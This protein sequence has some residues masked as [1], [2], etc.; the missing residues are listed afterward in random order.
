MSPEENNSN[1]D[2]SQ[3]TGLSKIKDEQAARERAAN[4]TV[5]DYDR[6]DMGSPEG[7]NINVNIDNIVG[8]PQVKDKLDAERAEAE[9]AA[10]LERSRQQ[11]GLMSLGEGSFD[12][13]REDKKPEVVRPVTPVK[14]EKT[15]LSGPPLPNP[16]REYVNYTYNLSFH[17]I[18]PEIYNRMAVDKNYVY[19][20]KDQ[21]GRGTVLIAS[22]GRRDQK[23]FDRHPEFK[24]DFYFENLK[25]TTVV[26]MNSRSRHSNAIEINFTL[27]EPYGFTLI[28]RLLKI[29]DQLNTKSWMQIPFML[30]ID[31]M[32][33]T[34]EGSVLHP[35]PNQTKYL[36]VKLIGCKSKVTPRGAEYQLQCVPFNHQAFTETIASTPAHFEVQATTIKDFFSVTGSAGEAENIIRVRKAGK[37]R[38]DQLAKQIEDEKKKDP[39]SPRIAELGREINSLNRDI[40]T[41]GYQVGSYAAALNSYQLQLQKNNHIRITEEFNFVFDPE[42]AD[43]KIVVPKKTTAN[44]TQMLTLGTPGG[45]AAIRAQAGLPTVGANTNIETFAINAGTNI[46]EVISMAMRNSEFIRNQIIDPATEPPENFSVPQDGQKAADDAGK[47]IVWFKIIPVLELREFDT[48]RDIYAKKITYHVKKFTY[49]NTKFRD[50]PKSRPTYN[51]KEYHYMYSGK[52]ESILSFDI[53]FDVMFYTAITADRGKIQTTTVQSKQPDDNKDDSQSAERPVGVTNNVTQMVS[54][55]ADQVNPGSPDSKASLV[56]DFSKSMMSSSRGDMINVNLKI[57]G[58]P[59]LIKQDDLFFN[60]ANN[61]DQRVDQIVDP[62]SN[63]IIFDATEVFALLTFRT[64]TDINLNTGFMNFDQAEYSVFSGV[65]KIITVENEF[66]R[67]QFTQ[68]LQLVRLFDQPAWDSPESMKL[69]SRHK[70]DNRPLT[71]AEATNPTPNPSTAPTPTTPVTLTVGDPIDVDLFTGVDEAVA[72]QK[73]ENTAAEAAALERSRQ[74]MGLMSLGEGSFNGGDD[75]GSNLATGGFFGGAARRKYEQAKAAGQ[76]TTT[77]TINPGVA[78]DQK[79]L[80]NQ[81]EDIPQIDYS[82]IFPN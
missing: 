55:Q 74:Q 75:N 1:I 2:F 80:R 24:E 4:Q 48:K 43:S 56:N 25:F 26:G 16:L 45:I 9:R 54:G 72:R 12:G 58:D 3:I 7:N 41:M 76:L 35:I 21:N 14:V 32:G 82:A 81:L 57:I 51:C 17:V 19:I 44:R 73:E 6:G 79:E 64:P 40:Q 66:S 69:K 27:I 34:N 30:Q 61:P 20:P 28:N 31:F 5:N 50:A 36:P 29:A 59:H 78:R 70:T 8:L 67:G 10:A 33:N 60:P 13:G 18:P 71:V 65:Y 22:A 63:S 68:T 39:K 23:I 11:M 49:Y 77:P 42:F 52:N 47:P 38:Q 53:D 37:E 62:R 46:L 15:P